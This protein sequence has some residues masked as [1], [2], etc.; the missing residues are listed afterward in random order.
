MG[1]SKGQKEMQLN[2]RNYAIVGF[3]MRSSPF[4]SILVVR[5]LGGDVKLAMPVFDRLRVIS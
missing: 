1:V 4:L 2:I 5:V 3:K